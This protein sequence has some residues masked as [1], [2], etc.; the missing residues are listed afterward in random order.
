MTSRFHLR[1]VCWLLGLLLAS[2]K[3]L[4]A[5]AGL[6]PGPFVETSILEW[7]Q[8]PDG[9]M[10]YRDDRQIFVRRKTYRPTDTLK[11]PTS[12][13]I[14]QLMVS[15]CW[16]ETFFYTVGGTEVYRQRLGGTPT[17]QFT[18][19]SEPTATRI[20]YLFEDPHGMLCLLLS[21]G[22]LIALN[23]ASAVKT[24]VVPLCAVWAP[25]IRRLVVGTDSGIVE[26]SFPTEAQPW[27][28]RQVA[29]SAEPIH[30]LTLD[31]TGEGVWAAGRHHQL[32]FRGPGGA[33][34]PALPGYERES[35]PI[36]FLAV[37]GPN[38]V[39]L[40][41]RGYGLR[42]VYFT[43]QRRKVTSVA[44][45]LA[46]HE[47]TSLFVDHEG[48]LRLGQ[49]MAPSLQDVQHWRQRL[50]K[51]TAI[52][53]ALNCILYLPEDGFLLGTSEGLYLAAH[54]GDPML[55][56]RQLTS[57][58]IQALHRDSDGVLWL[59]TEADGV[60][61]MV[62]P[63]AVPRQFLGPTTPHHRAIRVI[64]STQDGNLW[65]GSDHGV[66]RVCRGNPRNRN[67]F[68]GWQLGIT[69]VVDQIYPINDTSVLAMTG[70]SLVA[71]LGSTGTW[72]RAFAGLR[73]RPTSYG[74]DSSGNF[75]LG[76]LTAGVWRGTGAGNRLRRVDCLTANNVFDLQSDPPAAFIVAHERGFSR[77][78]GLSAATV[79][80]VDFPLARNHSPIQAHGSHCADGRLLYCRADSIVAISP[81]RMHSWYRSPEIRL[82]A[83]R[84]GP[85][86]LPLPPQALRLHLRRPIS[87]YYTGVNWREA[88]GYQLQGK[89]VPNPLVRIP[90]FRD[91]L[92]LGFLPPGEYTLS[93]QAQTAARL[94]D[95]E[96]FWFTVPVP[97]WRNP[98]FLTLALIGLGIG[99]WVIL[100][101]R[102]RALKA[103]NRRLGT[104]VREIALGKA[105]YEA[106]LNALP[107][108][109]F[110]VDQNGMVEDFS[111]NFIPEL[112]QRYAGRSPFGLAELLGEVQGRAFVDFV[113]RTQANPG[114]DSFAFRLIVAAELRHYQARISF[115]A[116]QE[117][118][119]VLAR[120]VTETIAQVEEKALYE[121]KL[122]TIEFKAQEAEKE[123]LARNLHDDL[124]PVITTAIQ[125]IHVLKSH[126]QAENI[127]AHEDL[128]FI[129]SRLEQ[130]LEI[131][132]QISQ[133]MVPVAL[134][135]FGLH[136]GLRETLAQID[137]S[138]TT[139]LQFY[140]YG[141]R[142]C[143]PPTVSRAVYRIIMTLV[144]NA[145]RHAE[146]SVISI[147]IHET[148]WD[149]SVTIEDDGVGFDLEEARKKPGLGLFSLERRVIDFGGE[150][151]VDTTIDAGTVISFEIPYSVAVGE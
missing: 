118:I 151:E 36:N 39:V 84:N 145:I 34:L 61:R 98:W 27:R 43:P 113:A 67:Y 17:R 35:F 62:S 130:G 87:F 73:D 131:V 109:M 72:E 20:C 57:R 119:I 76:T 28:V 104:L 3:D 95:L 82:E 79:N 47:I 81:A 149:I 126:T 60:Y 90:P 31:Y 65:L 15:R 6:E 45:T 14:A 50:V 38:S 101:L 111:C 32:L 115:I 54:L 75:V 77:L 138:V 4:R 24:G 68:D 2:G 93:V 59:G 51:P 136:N 30:T 55:P 63:T 133:D 106:V 120:D 147:Q 83:F 46:P 112:E 18:L 142:D 37:T 96:K 56:A 88:D 139:K 13:A 48:V 94:V 86:R 108:V 144:Q 26:I 140:H 80:C 128:Q 141:D 132:R 33:W 92:A 71:R 100:R 105:R 53:G 25:K 74:Q 70:I 148:Q 125:R 121:R 7:A 107:D 102:T 91:S 12:G 123:K 78:S 64:T 52:T 1:L 5:D 134:Q 127:L 116:G 89:L 21:D 150:F 29:S 114:I 16:P 143:A 44:T 146:A 9:T 11:P 69:P 99:G 22:H 8:F 129:R 124:G 66:T 85:Q 41:S 97:V 23:G 42:Q 58:P 117:K 40:G 49:W 103:S 10:L 19:P 135:Q 137:E 110:L 122:A